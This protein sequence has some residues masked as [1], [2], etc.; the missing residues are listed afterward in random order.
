MSHG[1]LLKY[2][3]HFLPFESY[4]SVLIWLEFRYW[5]GNGGYSGSCTSKRIFE[6]MPPSI[7]PS[8]HIVLGVG[9][10]AIIWAMINE[11]NDFLLTPLQC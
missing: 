6:F 4:S 8:L 9:L 11:I 2:F 10:C 5:W 1:N 3:D 7:A